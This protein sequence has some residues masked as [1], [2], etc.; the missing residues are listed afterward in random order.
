LANR[1]QDGSLPVLSR[2]RGS[3]LCERG[4]PWRSRM[5]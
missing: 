1:N 4:R 2:L 5:T 3:I